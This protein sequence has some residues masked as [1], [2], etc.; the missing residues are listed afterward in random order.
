MR[1]LTLLAVCVAALALAGCGHRIKTKEYVYPAWG[2]K[3]SFNVPPETKDTPAAA[4]GTPHSFL[5]EAHT[6]NHDF[7]VTAFDIPPPHGDL[8]G[9]GDS[10]SAYIA[11]HQ[12]GQVQGQTYVATFEDLMGREFR[13][14]KNGRPYATM[15]VFQVGDRFYEV[16]AVSAHGPSDPAVSDFLYSFHA[17]DA[18]G[19]VTNGL[20]PAAPASN[21]A[22]PPS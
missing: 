10:T 5:A 17:L 16:I 4:D 14:D 12:G 20:S 13:I 21:G 9:F 3:V 22:A 7:V 1:R 19:E 8:D 2:F 6:H 15:R 11:K 18:K